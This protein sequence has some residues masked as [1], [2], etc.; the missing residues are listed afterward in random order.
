M[1]L[2]AKVLSMLN[3]ANGIATTDSNNKLVQKAVYDANGNVIATTYATTSSVANATLQG[4]TFN[5]V[6]QLVQLLSNGKLPVLD[7]S[8]L[9]NTPVTNIAG[10][11]VNY[12]QKMTVLSSNSLA[13]DLSTANTF[14][15][16]LTASTTMTIANT[17]SGTVESSF[18]VWINYGAGSSITF[19][20]TVRWN[21]GITP[22]FATGNLYKLIFQTINNGTLWNVSLGGTFATS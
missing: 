9:I 3:I 14:S 13:I 19:P 6:S 2:G 7:G 5:G 18:D 17:A 20:S 10:T 12:N 11:I 4:N 8:N 22:T 15:A 16:T 21:N 1:N